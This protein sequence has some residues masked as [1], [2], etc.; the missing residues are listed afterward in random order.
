MGKSVSLRLG[1]L[2][3]LHNKKIIKRDKMKDC[4][5]NILNVGDRVIFIWGANN[6]PRLKI[7]HVTKIY[8]NDRE[9]SVDGHSHIFSKRVIKANITS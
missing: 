4:T 7:G 3:P 2:P 6:D 5:G 9:C 1:G 8:A